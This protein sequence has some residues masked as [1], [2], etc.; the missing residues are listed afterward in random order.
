MKLAKPVLNEAGM[1][2]FAEG[3]ILTEQFMRRL[4]SMD[5]A[6]VYVEGSSAPKRPLQEELSLLDARFRKI[7]GEPF[8]LFIKKILK[9]HIESLYA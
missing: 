8:M 7:E 4:Q 5:V 6:A 1:T 2:M 9:E 3:A